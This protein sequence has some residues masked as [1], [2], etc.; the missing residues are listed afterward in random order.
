[1][2]IFACFELNLINDSNEDGVDASSNGLQWFLDVS[3]ELLEFFNEV[4]SGL[5]DWPLDFFDVDGEGGESFEVLLGVVDDELEG[6]DLMGAMLLVVADAADDALLD[7][8]GLK[9]D[10]VEGLPDMGASLGALGVLELLGHI[11]RIYIISIMRNIYHT[12]ALRWKQ[13]LHLIQASLGQKVLSLHGRLF[14]TLN[15]LFV[16]I[17]DCL[18]FTM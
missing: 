4:A 13:G 1:M 2:I 16:F 14:L 10:Q 6:F 12:S 7:A 8:L 15:G 3:L 5:L 18:M 11:S 9:A 17:L